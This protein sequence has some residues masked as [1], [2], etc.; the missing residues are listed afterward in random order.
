MFRFL[1]SRSVAFAKDEFGSMTA[2]SLVLLVPLLMLAG[3][4]IDTGNVMASR[5]QLQITADATAHAALLKR[6]F[7]TEAEAKQ[8]ALSVAAQNMPSTIFGAVIEEDDIEFGNWDHVSSTF[9]ADPG[10]RAA[11]R[12]TAH[13]LQENGN[14]VQTFL[15][16][17]VGLTEWNLNQSAI[18]TTYY[19]TCLREGFVAEDV[20]DLQS[21]N[22][23]SNGFCVHSNSYVSMNS[24]NYFEP[25]TVVSMADTD[26][27]ELPNSG[28]ATNTGLQEALREGSWN[29]RIVSRIQAII[30]GLSNF[31]SRYLPA[32]ITSTVPVTFSSRNVAQADLIEGRLHKFTC[33][34]GAALTITNGVTV[35]N[36]VIVTNCDVKFG[37]GVILDNAVIATTNVGD[38][39]MTAASG[40]QVGRNDNCAAD[41]GSQLVTLGSMDFPADLKVYGGQLLAVHDISFAANANGIQGAAFVAGGQISGTSNMAMGFCGSGMET[42]F[43]AEYFKL[44]L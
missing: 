12:V 37:S 7:A 25:G 15:L 10:S 23:F 3:Y 19:P 33:N 21:N 42:S 20:V 43:Q 28:F 4:A 24:N 30:T 36:A 29:I 27:L 38:H 34:G 8:S 44:V 35:R 22:N 39:S 17:F 26:D 2:L 16:K 13:R 6:E 5:T 41:G 40:V 11:V 18:F 9:T 1:K 32:Y 14:A 31:D